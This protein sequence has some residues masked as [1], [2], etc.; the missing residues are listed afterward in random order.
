MGVVTIFRTRRDAR[1]DAGGSQPPGSAG[2]RI[3]TGYVETHRVRM[4]CR[5]RM[6]IGDVERAYRRQ[7]SLG[8]IEAW[9]CPVGEWDGD[10][11]V[12]RGWTSCLRAALMLGIEWLLVAWIEETRPHG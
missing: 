10:T 2:R 5:D 11:F 12:L 6:S 3:V 4:A 1:P 8:L 9:P 7:L